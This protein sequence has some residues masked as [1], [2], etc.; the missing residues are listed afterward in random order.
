MR[1]YSDVAKHTRWLL[2]N[3]TLAHVRS[4]IVHKADCVCVGFYVLPRARSTGQLNM[5]GNCA[6]SIRA[7]P[8]HR[9]T[10]RPSKWSSVV[11]LGALALAG[12]RGS[13]SRTNPEHKVAIADTAI[14]DV[15]CLP[16]LI[17][18]TLQA[19]ELLAAHMHL[20]SCNTAVR[21]PSKRRSGVTRGRSPPLSTS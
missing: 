20:Q 15:L 9:L 16:R 13:N 17:V 3:T 2:H 14:R 7:C 11:D 10:N 21:V 19:G 18:M 12:A 4:I 8:D 6:K 1:L 5:R